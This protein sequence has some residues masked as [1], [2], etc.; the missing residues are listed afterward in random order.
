VWFSWL[1]RLPVA[2]EVASSSLVVP[3]ILED[4][5]A[6][7]SYRYALLGQAR[8]PRDSITIAKPETFRSCY[9]TV[10]GLDSIYN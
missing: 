8:R 5:F 4:W 9:S 7:P 2:A 10:L 3:A 1:E 6:S